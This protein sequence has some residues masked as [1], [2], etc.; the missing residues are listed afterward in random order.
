MLHLSALD[1]W[2]ESIYMSF[3]LGLL[4]LHTYLDHDYF[5]VLLKPVTASQ[6]LG[7]VGSD[8][9]VINTTPPEVMSVRYSVYP[10]TITRNLRW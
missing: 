9:W 2:R 8:A 1:D 7:C 4:I 6:L 3:E 5:E 10:E